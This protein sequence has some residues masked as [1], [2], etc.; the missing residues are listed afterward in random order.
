MTFKLQARKKSTSAGFV[1]GDK[2][3]V[4]IGRA[5]ERDRARERSPQIVPT[6]R[7][8]CMEVMEVLTRPCMN[9]RTSRGSADRFPQISSAFI[10]VKSRWMAS[11]SYL[12]ERSVHA[13]S[14][15]SILEASIQKFRYLSW[16][17]EG[18]LGLSCPT[19]VP[20][21]LCLPYI[22]V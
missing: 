12:A 22:C 7:K 19:T 17:E 15:K 6:P 11:G 20:N 10:T 14:S 5:R 21:Y 2:P 4:S 16:L 8:I 3:S 13:T 1:K 9:L 18:Y